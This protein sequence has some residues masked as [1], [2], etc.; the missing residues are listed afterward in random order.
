MYDVPTGESAS[1]YA[2]T[3]RPRFDRAVAQ[4]LESQGYETFLPQYRRR[5]HHGM[6]SQDP[7]MPLFPGYVL[8]RFDIRRAS[9]VVDTPGVIR[10]LGEGAEPAALPGHEVASL[11]TAIRAGLPLEPFPFVQRGARMRIER[12]ALAGVEGI[13]VSSRAKVRLVLSIT[14]LQKSALLEIARDELLLP[15]LHAAAPFDLAKGA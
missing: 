11:Q 7:E 9:P 2:L 1:W 12:G 13:V 8:C 3:V 10:I 5:P 4:A 15:D 14:L 6:P